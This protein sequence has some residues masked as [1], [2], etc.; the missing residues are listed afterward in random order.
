MQSLYSI[1]RPTR[2]HLLI[3]DSDHEQARTFRLQFNPESL[4]RKIATAKIQENSGQGRQRGYKSKTDLGSPTETMTI[5]IRLDH[6]T[7]R[8]GARKGESD[9]D[10]AT[11]RA[12]LGLLPEL[13]VLESLA[14]PSKITRAKSKK[15]KAKR[16]PMRVE[17]PT[18]VLVWGNRSFPVRVTSV[19]VNE[20][21][22]D[23]S[24]VPIRAEVELS[25]EL[26]PGGHYRGSKAREDQRQHHK[27]R[28]RWGELYY[29]PKAKETQ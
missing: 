1:T 29:G 28:E 12:K 4:T 8:E 23:R 9:E 2:A 24:L 6:G 22:H 17:W 19:N 18:V 7:R 25:M 16:K 26:R 20:L 5:K 15:K 21:L 13:A 10:K 3:R 14:H 11:E 27:Q